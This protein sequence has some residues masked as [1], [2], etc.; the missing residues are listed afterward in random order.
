MRKI[1][2]IFV[3]A[4]AC[5]WS[6]T[7]WYW[8]TCKIK[9]ICSLEQ[10][11]PE[12]IGNTK[13]VSSTAKQDILEAQQKKTEI[14]ENTKKDITQEQEKNEEISLEEKIDTISKESSETEI[15]KSCEDIV[16][17]AIWLWSENKEEEVKNLER[18]LNRIQSWSLI[19]DG[20]YGQDDFEAVKKFQLTYKKDIL[21]PW[22]IEKPT[23]YV[24][25]TTIQKI[26]EI[27]CNN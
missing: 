17:S 12:T 9:W 7:S 16:T 6:Y 23:G 14:L 27:H 5:L 2:I 20:V 10:V 25:K 15:E 4:L 18:F 3:L 24:Y 22:N 26:N 8:Y 13:Q 1:A 11:T 21:D 19:V